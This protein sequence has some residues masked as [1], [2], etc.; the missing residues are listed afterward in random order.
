MGV[1]SA[2]I[3]GNDT[4]CEVKEY[5][6]E[7]YDL[8]REPQDIRTELLAKYDMGD[9]EERYNVLFAMAYCLWQTKELDSDFLAE[10]EGIVTS[11]EDIAVCE[12]LGANAKFLRERKGALAKL[13]SDIG[14]P[15]EKPKKRVKPPVTVDSPYRNGCCLAFQYGD[16]QWGAVVTIGSEFFRRK[17]KICFVQTD[18]RQ[19][20]APT[21]QEINAAHLLDNYF[22]RGSEYACDRKLHLYGTHFLDS[23]EVVRL[24]PYNESFFVVIGYLPEWKN[25]HSGSSCGS[26]P[27]A[28]EGYGGFEAIIQSYFTNKF[29]DTKRTAET[30]EELNRVFQG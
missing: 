10:I 4:S 15:K 7:Q 17:A 25:A 9:V 3:F 16:G 5:F 18:I 1:W 8:G 12:G 14:T 26:N 11:G 20:T 28:E 2:A 27:Y 23:R 24:N 6:F 22:D 29:N 13:L 19:G 21:M 30:V